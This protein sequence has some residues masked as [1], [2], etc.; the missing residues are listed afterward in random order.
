MNM[1]V[2][3]LNSINRLFVMPALLIIF[4]LI[5]FFIYNEIKNKTINEFNN[6][7]LILAKTASQGITSFFENYQSDLTFLSKLNNIIDFSEEGKT[8]ISAFYNTHRSII[9]A[10][11][12]VDARGIIMYTYP[13]DQSVTDRDISYQKHVQKVIAEHQPV[14][15]DVFMS[16]QGYLAIAMH[17]PVFK[18]KKF[19]GSLAILI[20]M[21]ELG[22]LYLGKI[23]NKKNGHAWLLSK[24]G[25]EIYCPI[26]GHTGKSF[27]ETLRNDDTSH[28]LLEKMKTQNSGTARGLH[29]DS[30]KSQRNNLHDMYFVFYRIPLENTY[31]TILISY[32]KKAVYKALSQ[33]RNRLIFLFFLLFL[34]VSFYFYSLAKVQKILNEEAKRKKAERQL[35]KSEEKFRKIFEEHTAAKL[36]IDPETGRIT[37]ANKAACDY[38]GWSSEELKQMKMEHLSVATTREIKKIFENILSKK[39]SQFE[40]RHRLKDGSVRDV[41]VFSSKV[42]INGKVLLHSIVHDISKRKQAEK[43]LKI[44]AW[45]QSELAE[46]GNQALMGT[47]LSTLFSM[48]TSKIPEILDMDFCTV[49]ERLSEG[50][51]AKIIAGSGW[52]DGVVGEATVNI[53]IESQAG[54]TI[55]SKKPV[56]VDDFSTETRFEV[57]P[58]LANQGVVSGISVIIGKAENPFGILSAHTKHHK[59]FT[60][61]DLSFFQAMANILAEAIERKQSELLLLE[62]TNEIEAQNEEYLQINEELHQ[63]NEELY[64]EKEHAEE[65]DRLKTSF[66]QNMSHEIRTPMNAIMGFSSM[67]PETYNNRERLEEYSR[68]I[69]LRSNDLLEIINDILDVSKIESGLLEVNMEECNLSDLFGELTI[70]FTEHQKRIGKQ[71]IEFNLNY[72]CDPSKNIIVTDKVKLKQIFINLINNAFKF[73]ETGKIEGGCKTDAQ[74]N[75]LFY[76]SDTGIGIPADKQDVIFERFT[77]LKQNK[78]FTYGGTGLGLSI[79]KGLVNLLGGE[80]WLESE[81]ADMKTGKNGNTTFYFSL[82]YKTIQTINHAAASPVEDQTF[83]FPDKTILLVEDDLFNVAYIEEVLSD[84]GIKIIQTGYGTEAIEIA[85]KQSPDLILMDIRLPDIDGYEA[86]NQMKNHN[87]HIKIIAQTAYASENDKQKALDAGCNDYISKPIERKQLL[88]MI[89]EQLNG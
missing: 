29:H 6:E 67:L 53:G 70:F 41:E 51:T 49:L 2:F 5:F 21:D 16:A 20:P 7:Q 66:L 59:V 72:R 86:I 60:T 88:S 82:A 24:N 3:R 4:F 68:I 57:P 37:D 27:F 52:K 64:R 62:K 46:L 71:H 45:Q 32:Q 31:W 85:T 15:S 26:K 13:N 80:I 39:R 74:K 40:L 17:V 44:R 35:Q 18:N 77:Q 19:A 34:A 8:L 54:F 55:Q 22:K 78:N 87:P 83:H 43:K 47:D 23:E 1:K 73:T 48:A 42:K 63:T 9:T 89:K 69:N 56:I 75:L 11:T 79:V 36:I 14:I 58:L 81:P 25:T 30:I 50:N 38:Y 84:T 28:S 61:E 76:V 65:S 33:F 10:V 12:R